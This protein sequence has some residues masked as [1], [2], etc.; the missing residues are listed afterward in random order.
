MFWQKK[1]LAYESALEEYPNSI[2]PS[3]KHIPVW[4]KKISKWKN[5]K[6][7]TEDGGL[8]TTLRHCMPF[9]ETM[10]LGYMVTLPYDLYVQDKDGF[11][12]LGWK[13]I[14]NEKQ[15]SWRK[16][17]ANIN[18]V[19]TGHYPVEYIWNFCTSFSVPKGCSLLITH[20]LNRH[21]LPFTTLSGVIDGSFV[22]QSHGSYPFYLKKGFEGLIPQG[23]PIAQLIPFSQENWESKKIDGL[24]KKGEINRI[25]SD[26]IFENWYKKKFWQKKEYW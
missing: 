2:D 10:T 21:D 19:P 4:Y 22:T 20:P 7:F 9:L 26:Q 6:M 17:T 15:P 18:L 16:E 11:P 14:E 12:Y 23:T 8:Q 3:K 24:V 5:N 25:S 1:I 13:K